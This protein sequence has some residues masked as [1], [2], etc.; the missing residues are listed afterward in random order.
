[1]DTALC[2]VCVVVSSILDAGLHVCAELLYKS[3]S[4]NSILA[5]CEISWRGPIQKASSLIKV[6]IVKYRTDTAQSS[7]GEGVSRY[8]TR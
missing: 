8:F 2:A 3:T 6:Q 4:A 1:M 7:R 5:E